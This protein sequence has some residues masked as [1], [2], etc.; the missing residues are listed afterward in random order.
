MSAATRFT[1]AVVRV[2]GESVANGLRAGSGAD[3]DPARFAAHHAAYTR[4]LKEAGLAVVEL[5][6]L[7]NFPD[8]TFV[9]DTALCLPQGAILMRPGAPSRM[10]EVAGIAPT[11]RDLYGDV[12]SI[13]TGHVEGGD[14]LVT[15]REV[16]VGR[17]ARTDAAGI[18]TLS[19]ILAEWGHGLREVETPPEILH[20][21]TDC[22]LLDEETVLATPR[23]AATRC[24]DGYRVIETASGEE[25]SANCVRV[26]ETVLF[27]A[28]FPQTAERLRDAGYTLAELPNG[29]AAKID[30]GMSCLSLRFTSPRG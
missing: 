12:R 19:P 27:P 26:N 11:L 23:L 24:F 14:I 17:S 7:E 4:A 18:E 30:G 9:E 20:F 2:P 1:H 5:R 13:E 28:G 25:A 21:K 16:L 3:P 10:G 6:P 22:G 8:A 29:E 15:A